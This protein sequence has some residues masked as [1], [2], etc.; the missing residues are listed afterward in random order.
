MN[1]PLGEARSR[2]RALFQAWDYPGALA[3]FEQ[4]LVAFPQNSYWRYK[5]ADVFV[6]LDLS[7]EASLVY[8]RVAHAD[9]QSGRPLAAI[10]AAQALH[11]LG[12]PTDD[13]FGLLS[14]IYASGSP[15][16]AR[17]AIRRPTAPTE[18]PI[19]LHPLETSES[20]DAL[21]T[22]AK[23]RALDFSHAAPPLQQHNPLP[24]LSELDP[25]A[26]NEVLRA[27]TI[28]RFDEPGLV[29]RQGEVAHSLYLVA[30]GEV[31][32]FT[33]G[34]DGRQ[35]EVAR[36]QENSLFGEMALITLQPR[37]AS[38][39][40][41]DEADI[42]AI[43]RTSLDSLTQRLPTL[44]LAL[45]RF[46]RQRLIKNLLVSSPL[47]TPFSK[48]QQAELLRRFENHDV[49]EGTDIIQEGEAGR[50]LFVV[51]SGAVDVVKGAALPAP[52]ALATLH[53]GE[54]FG[55]MSLVVGQ[56][57]SATVRATT[58]TTLLFLARGYFE[59][60]AAAVP[61][62]REHFQSV[63]MQRARDNTLRLGR[64][65]VPEQATEIDLDVTDEI[66]L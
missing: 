2:A 41:V 54:I 11:A 53:P 21:V 45:A 17:V 23:A 33:T 65:A 39:A 49:A 34:G 29:I 18:P 66:L 5:I 37:A 58:R 36:L 55:E 63:A 62:L 52:V 19:A 9:I 51:L 64:R 8:R 27:L 10:L 12:Q 28:K 24:F 1:T 44:G 35:K 4:L 48:P 6:R 31:R 15:H 59:R 13:I 50:G 60:L 40:V 42:I 30:R 43:S 32:V 20:L 16:L 7:E 56:P 57:A 3:G 46:T 14:D 61:E 47:F 25:A 22:R 26:L 38:I